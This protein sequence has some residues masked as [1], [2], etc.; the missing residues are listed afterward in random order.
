MI[1][2]TAIILA[3]LSLN[4]KEKYLNFGLTLLKKIIDFSFDNQISPNQE[5]FFNNFLPKIFCFN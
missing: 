3:G 4:E 2:C 1:G 5:T